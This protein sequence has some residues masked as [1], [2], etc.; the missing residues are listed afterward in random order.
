MYRIRRAFQLSLQHKL[1]PKEQWTKD[2][3]DVPYLSPI[4]VEI[5]KELAEKDALDSLTPLKKH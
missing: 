5:Q 4:I 3:D 1:L 2:A